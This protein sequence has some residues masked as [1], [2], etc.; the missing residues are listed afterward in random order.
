MWPETYV[1]TLSES[2]RAG[3]VPIV[4]DTGALGERVSHGVNGFKVPVDEPSAVVHKLRDILHDPRQLARI[5]RN[6]HEGLYRVLPD[7]LEFLVGHYRRLL[8]QY[9]VAERGPRFFDEAPGPRTAGGGRTF[10]LSPVWHV[11]ND[12]CHGGASLAYLQGMSQPSLVRR[13]RRYLRDHGVRATVRRA[14][15]ELFLRQ[16][17]RLP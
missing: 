8:D 4:T 11:P 13:A 5:R 2:S 7:H 15:R 17:I 14:V 6:I 3:V 9:R 1:L 16:G 12:A 10:R